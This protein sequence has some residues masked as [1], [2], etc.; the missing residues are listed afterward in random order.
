[1]IKKVLPII[2]IVAL[3]AAPVANAGF[4]SKIRAAI[5]AKLEQLPKTIQQEEIHEVESF[6][7]KENKIPT[8]KE[9]AAPESDSQC[10]DLQTISCFYPFP[11]QDWIV[12]ENGNKSVQ[13]PMDKIFDVNI[14]E[15]LDPQLPDSLK[16]SDI[17]QAFAIS[18]GF[19]P[20]TAV[21]FE[22][23]QAIDADALPSGGANAVIAI[24]LDTG[25]RQ[26]IDVKVSEYARSDHFPTASHMLEVYH[27]GRWEFSNRYVVAVTSDLLPEGMGRRFASHYK[28]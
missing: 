9:A 10:H 22:F 25:E 23:E 2:C 15:V 18:D 12:E 6:H 19:S 4:K 13:V 26:L 17:K 3:A 16:I 20:A 1:M 28:N 11:N 27:N 7:P 14:Q 21:M 8:L 5:N 24:N